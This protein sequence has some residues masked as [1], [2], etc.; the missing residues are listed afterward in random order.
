M[1]SRLDDARQR[2]DAQAPG[3]MPIAPVEDGV[4]GGACRG[5]GSPIGIAR[6]GLG[7][8]SAAVEARPRPRGS[9]L[10]RLGTR[11][12]L[13]ESFESS[14]V[15]LAVM[16]G[17]GL[18]LSGSVSMDSL[19]AATPGSPGGAGGVVFLNRTRQSRLPTVLDSRSEY[20][21]LKQ[22]HQIQ[23]LEQQNRALRDQ[24]NMN[25]G[26]KVIA[27]AHFT[28]HG[29]RR[30]QS[31]D[32][33]RTPTNLERMS[34]LGRAWSG[35]SSLLAILGGEANMNAKVKDDSEE[36]IPRR[37]FDTYKG[38]ME[39]LLAA[40]RSE[41]ALQRRDNTALSERNASLEQKVEELQGR[42]G[43]L[44]A[45]S[46]LDRKRLERELA[47]VRALLVERTRQLKEKTKEFEDWWMSTGR[48][49]NTND[50]GDDKAETAEAEVQKQRSRP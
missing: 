49:M 21:N 48:F 11:A 7:R 34:N 18:Q 30:P 19:R 42:Y 29:E 26:R 16:S 6:H 46:A 36:M 9:R 40:L 24:V 37:M 50:F 47:K 4:R 25:R 43:A 13:D 31:V 3:T 1:L 27:G 41:T 17:T 45:S 5:G 10:R 38:E 35:D 39:A 23:A 33:M 28:G 14:R 15:E 44:L 12:A 2:L 22:R 8:A 32:R 20:H